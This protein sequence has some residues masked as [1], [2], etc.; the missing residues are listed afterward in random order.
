MRPFEKLGYTAAACALLVLTFSIIGPRA[1]KAAVA[2]LVQVS[3]T[4]ANPVPTVELGNPGRIPYRVAQPPYNCDVQPV[5]L[6]QFP[7]VPAGH[8]L[9]IQHVSGGLDMIYTPTNV[10]MTLSTSTTLLSN[11]F[12]PVAGPFGGGIYLSYFDQPVLGYVDAGDAPQLNM[13]IGSP[14]TYGAQQAFFA[15]AAMQVVLSG[16]ELDCTIAACAPIATQ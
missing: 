2:T 4:S 14:A 7:T 3:N 1:V 8:R 16:Y 12:A 9:V 5:C 10:S 15:K 6:M 13:V 11:F